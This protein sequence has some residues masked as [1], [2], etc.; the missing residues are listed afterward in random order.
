MIDAITVISYLLGNQL[1]HQHRLKLSA[2]FSEVHPLVCA[3][4]VESPSLRWGDVPSGADS[5]AI[6]IKDANPPSNEKT[7]Y[8]WVVYNLPVDTTAL[9][10]GVSQYMLKNH[11]GINS[12]GEQAY[13][14]R[15][16]GDQVHPVS[17][18]LMALNGRIVSDK[19]MTGDEL[20]QEVRLKHQVLEQVSYRL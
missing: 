17:I 12:W 2:R 1:G 9:P 13:H 19:P 6:V 11:L 4:P 14:S 8:Y 16:W 15:C 20:E 10:F 18:E 3:H 5:V 7:H